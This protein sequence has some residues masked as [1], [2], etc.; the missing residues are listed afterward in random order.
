[1]TRHA[2]KCSV[3]VVLLV[4]LA[5]ATIHYWNDVVKLLD[6]IANYWDLIASAIIIFV[7]V[8]FLVCCWW[9]LLI[10]KKVDIACDK[11]KPLTNRPYPP[12][13]QKH[14]TGFRYMDDLCLGRL[15]E[16]D[17]RLGPEQQYIVTKDYR[18][19][20]QLDNEAPYIM[21]VPAGT[22]TDLSSAPGPFRMFVGRV[23]PHLEA[24]IVHDY[25]Y[26]AWQM[27][28]L[29]PTDEMRRFADKLMLVAMREAGMCCKAYAIYCAV[30]LFGTCV[31][32]G[33][34]P[35]PLKLEKDKRPDCCRL[36]RDE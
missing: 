7:G 15:K 18:V 5:L 26:I 10:Q 2:I 20:V 30:R 27:K 4:G 11:A 12:P 34:D 21:T 35:E 8:V 1:M 14:I 31:F 6:W 28:N 19:C 22:V 29:T 32:Y 3:I 24:T 16:R 17:K 36:E 25:L 9:P 13:R 23:G 33:R